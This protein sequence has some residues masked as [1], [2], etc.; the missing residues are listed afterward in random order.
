[1]L[2]PIDTDALVE[3]SYPLSQGRLNPMV[4]QS[5]PDNLVFFSKQI[6]AQDLEKVEMANE[7]RYIRK[8]DSVAPG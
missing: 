5:S 2:L 1:M 3:S 7:L 4:L 6:V 8:N